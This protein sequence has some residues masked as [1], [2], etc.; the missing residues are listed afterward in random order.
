MYWFLIPL[1]IGFLSNLAS[2]F[3]GFYSEKWGRQTGTFLTILLRDIFGIPVWAIGFLLAV[4][5]S[6]ELLYMTGFGVNATGWT[7]IAV[8]GIIIIAALLSI[9]LRAAAP[10]SGD[11][12]VDTGMYSFVRHPIHCGTFL[13]FAGLFVLWP[14]FTVGTAALI[15]TVWII[16]QSRF[17]ER[18]LKM[19][20]EGYEKYMKK[21]PGFIPLLRK[22][23]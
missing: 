9:R 14:S 16:F 17:E 1:I 12:L 7:L 20:I 23:L 19:R 5:D 3:T 13:E 8:G 11:T 6:G 22:K 10:S 15:G 21:V 18:D 2:S 4:R